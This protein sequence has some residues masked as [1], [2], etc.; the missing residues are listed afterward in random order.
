MFRRFPPVRLIL[1]LVIMALWSYVA[2]QPQTRDLVL[3]HLRLMKTP[4]R[5]YSSGNLDLNRAEDRIVDAAYGREQKRIWL[6]KYPNEVTLLAA[7]VRGYVGWL[8]LGRRRDG[9]LT[10]SFP[11]WSVITERFEGSIGG[12]PMGGIPEPSVSPIIEREKTDYYLLLT[13][14]GRR[15]EPQNTFWDWMEMAFLIAAQRDSEVDAVL[16]RA[17]TKSDF[18]DH[19]SDELLANRKVLSRQML[20]STARLTALSGI[21]YHHTSPMRLTT[22]FLAQRTMGLRLQGRDKEA[23]EHGLRAMRLAR[24]VRLKASTTSVSN[25]GM[26]YEGVIIARA[27]VPLGNGISTQSK[28]SIRNT[29]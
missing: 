4:S 19:V 25:Q 23:L 14:R 20:D 3:Q 11:Q 8:G 13:E 26:G 18:D 6:D 15:L 22:Y 24:L 5:L 16:R 12:M 2:W 17:A 29:N 7:H 1:A 27:Q 28:V 21:P 10:S 9:P